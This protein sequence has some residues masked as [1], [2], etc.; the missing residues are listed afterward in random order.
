MLEITKQVV[1][2]DGMY[3]HVENERDM[4]ITFS[5]SLL[6]TQEENPQYYGKRVSICVFVSLLSLIAKKKIELFVFL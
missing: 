3:A 1:N 2:V 5:Q 6:R 4:Q